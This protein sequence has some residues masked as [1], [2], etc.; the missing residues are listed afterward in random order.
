MFPLSTEEKV[1][2][3][4]FYW[5]TR[6]IIQTQRKFRAQF[7]KKRTLTRKTILRLCEGFI[8]EGSVLNQSRGHSGRPIS[9]RTPDVIKKVRDA[10]ERDPSKSIRKIAQEV[11]TNHSTV[12]KILTKDL[13][14]KPYKLPV[15]QQLAPHD[16]GQ[17]MTFSSWLKEK[18]R[19]NPDFL[20]QV[21]FSDEAH[22]C[23]NGKVNRQNCRIWASEKPE[24]VYQLP[25]HSPRVTVWCAMSASGIIGPFWFET[26]DG[27]TTT[28]TTDRYISDLNKFL[29]ELR[30]AGGGAGDGDQ[31]SWW[32]QQ[33]GASPHTAKLTLAWLQEHFG[34]RVISRKTSHPWPPHSPDL[35]PLDFFLWGYLKSK[36]YQGDPQNLTEL[37]RAIKK[38]VR[39]ISR[40]TCAKVLREVG[41]RA[42]LCH[43]R[44]GGLFEHAL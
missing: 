26:S 30:R 36:V 29:K 23:L 16:E 41:K 43:S 12:R 10:I 28:V 20:Q 40:E 39:G 9:K 14:L 17:R 4:D 35:T 8:K 7:G 34:D 25:L 27:T 38:E 2:L 11:G 19:E 5:N 33:D 24:D 1:K 3:V 32:F 42:Q 21:W 18:V 31:G 6:S 13:N 44:K 22:F 15:H 37:K